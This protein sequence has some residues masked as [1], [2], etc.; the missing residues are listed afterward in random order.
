PLAEALDSERTALR[1]DALHCCHGHLAP[2]LVGYP[3]DELVAVSAAGVRRPLV[4]SPHLLAKRGRREV[5]ERLL[6]FGGTVAQLVQAQIVVRA[7]GSAEPW[8]PA[9][10]SARPA[11][12]RG[13]PPSK[14]RAPPPVGAGEN[15]AR[16]PPPPPVG[17][18]PQR[19]HQV[20]QRL[21]GPGAR[22]DSQVRAA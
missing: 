11:D 10:G 18:Q 15:N 5:D 19:G 13:R 17:G 2:R 1:S 4:H 6:L 8:G 22:L 20:G 16:P 3:G 7:F 14:S 21:A 12:P 9:G